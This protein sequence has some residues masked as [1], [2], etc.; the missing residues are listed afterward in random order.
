LPTIY[1]PNTERDKKAFHKPKIHK[2]KRKRSMEPAK[3]SSIDEMINI[4]SMN[5]TNCSIIDAVN[6]R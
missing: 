6:S 1:N 3:T 5:F 4:Q 2:N